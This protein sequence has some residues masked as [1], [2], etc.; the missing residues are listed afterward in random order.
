MN[1]AFEQTTLLPEPSPA[2]VDAITQDRIRIR[3]K[4]TNW[5]AYVYVPNAGDRPVAFS[6]G[7]SVTV[8]GIRGIRLIVLS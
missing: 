1:F 8:V 5:D 4:A 6:P 7:Q 2:T 3:W